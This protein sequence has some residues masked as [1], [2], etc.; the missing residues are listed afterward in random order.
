MRLRNIKNAKEII[1]NYDNYINNP[2]DYKGKWNKV[3]NNNNPIY[4]EIGMGKG[5][6]IKENALKNSNINYIGIDR[7]D[8]IV[9]KA[10]KNMPK[11]DNLR[12]IRIDANDIEK[13][14]DN[15]ISLIFLNFSDPWPKDRHEKR[16]LTDT[17]FLI[18]YD[19]IFKNNNKIILKTDNRNLFEYSIISLSKYG[20]I[21]NNI[22]LDLHNK[23]DKDIITTEYEEK[24]MKNGN[25][26]Y[27]L[28]CEKKNI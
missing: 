17:N 1:N 22:S 20:Y 2:E 11:I 18:K 28:E 26:I 16:R 24:F 14:F 5:K 8:A 9:A 3:F 13:V 10:I 25:L 23:V 4:I 6:F 7:Y 15:E 12:I 21:I 27:K 19:N